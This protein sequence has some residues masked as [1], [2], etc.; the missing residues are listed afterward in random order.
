MGVSF[1]EIL[2]S[3]YNFSHD[4]QQTKHLQRYHGKKIK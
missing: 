4:T 1:F 2:N 3:I